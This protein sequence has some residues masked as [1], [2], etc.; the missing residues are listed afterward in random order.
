[1]SSVVE[2]TYS[3]DA[4]KAIKE[5]DGTEMKGRKV[6]VREVKFNIKIKNLP[7]FFWEMFNSK[8]LFLGTW[9]VFFV[10]NWSDNSMLFCCGCGFVYVGG[11]GL[12][13]YDHYM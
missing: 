13:L 1:M 4:Q 5:F 8:M 3:K 2:F 11:G 9:L 7:Q 6:K 10:R 12:L